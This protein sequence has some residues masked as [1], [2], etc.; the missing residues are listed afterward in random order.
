MPTGWPEER[1]LLGMLWDGALCVDTALPFGWCF[2]ALADTVG[3]IL[4][5]EGV[6]CV[7]PLSG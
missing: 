4:K 1:L 5:Q 6:A 2:N 3:W 7:F